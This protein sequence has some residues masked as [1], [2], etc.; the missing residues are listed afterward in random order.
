MEALGNF[1][2]LTAGYAQDSYNRK[3]THE[4]KS[5][6]IGIFPDVFRQAPP[7]HPIRNE[8]QRASSNPSKG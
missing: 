1:A 8:L 4:F 5:I 6:R 7:R 2:Q 3:G